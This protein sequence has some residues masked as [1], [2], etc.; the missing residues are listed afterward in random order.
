MAD[1][2]AN[3]NS[4]VRAA[5]LRIDPA[6]TLAAVDKLDLRAHAKVS[7]VVGVPLRQLQQ[8]RD[9]LAFAT[10]APPAAVRALLEQLAA[11][12]LEKIVE[13]L[14]EHA[15]SP[16]YE[17]LSGAVDQLLSEGSVDDAVAVLAYAIG[18]SFPAAANCRRLLED[19]PDLALPSLPAVVGPS[20]LAS[21]REVSPAIREQRRARR[22]EERRRKKPGA[23]T[24]PARP[25]RQKS[26]SSSP[27]LAHPAGSRL[28]PVSVVRRRVPLTPLEVAR[29]DPEHPL[30]AAVVIVD[31]PFDA[32]DA[33][34]PELSSKE[35]PALVVAASVS[36]L[37]VRPIYSNPSPT[38]TLF[39]PWRRV[40]LDHPSY[41]D[42]ARVVV[43]CAGI[44]AQLTQLTTSEWNALLG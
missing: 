30:V 44:V 24:R 19:R 17:E 3:A 12:P 26:T 7:A 10:T 39:R 35:R 13:L 21:P 33:L 15:E 14:G 37:L 18:E 1:P 8:R 25:A 32:E 16:T 4:V 34:Q 22:E 31:V 36:E 27:S 5:L 9:V 2:I 40:G 20:V 42:A 38:R 28:A 11:Q 6:T 43:P 29:F 41:I 23:S